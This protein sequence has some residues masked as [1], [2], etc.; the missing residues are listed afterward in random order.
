MKQAKSITKMTTIT[1]A[2]ALNVSF[3][4]YFIGY[5]FD[6]FKVYAYVDFNASRK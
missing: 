3:F 5:Y 2:T 4:I 6:I 1:I